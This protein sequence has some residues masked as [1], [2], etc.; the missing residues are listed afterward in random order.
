L[1]KPQSVDAFLEALTHRRKREVERLRGIILAAAPGVTEQ[2]KW[3]A[4]SFG[5]A[6]QDRVT[7]RLQPGDRLQVILHRGAKVLD[8]SGFVFSEPSGLV[9]WLARD[10]GEVSIA[11]AD[12]LE[13]RAELLGDLVGRWMRETRGD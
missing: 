2:V 6:G 1:A 5:I 9:R 12:E 7:M 4:P 11:D 13:A 8:A 10:R 3:N